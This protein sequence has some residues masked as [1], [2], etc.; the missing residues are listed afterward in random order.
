M[1][2]KEKAPAKKPAKAKATAT[3]TKITR[4]KQ[5]RSFGPLKWLVA[6]FI[7]LGRYLGGSWK[8]LREVRWPNR[9]TTWGLTLAVL[10]FSGVLTLFIILLDLLFDFISKRILL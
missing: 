8:E 5:P 4:V 10:L 6:P 9:K 2:G 3:V 1:A 7:A